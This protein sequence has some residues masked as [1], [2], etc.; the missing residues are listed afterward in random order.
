MAI[1]TLFI[2]LV[3]GVIDFKYQLCQFSTLLQNL[4]LTVHAYI[5]LCSSAASLYV[6][7]SGLCE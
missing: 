4:D 3:Y 1:L 6:K 5:M 7:R 2:I